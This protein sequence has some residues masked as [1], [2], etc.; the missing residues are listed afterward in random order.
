MSIL[1]MK[2]LS[3]SVMNAEREAVL[4]SLQNLGCVHLTNLS[5][6]A[7]EK[8]E[9]SLSALPFSAVEVD[10][11]TLD[12]YLDTLEDVIDFLDDYEI[13]NDAGGLFSSFKPVLNASHLS[14]IR[15]Q[16]ELEHFLRDAEYVDLRFKEFDA[17][18]SAL[19]KEESDL[20]L[21]ADSGLDLDMLNSKSDVVGAY[22]GVINTGEFE[23]LKTFLADQAPLSEAFFGFDAEDGSHVYVVYSLSEKSTVSDALRTFGFSSVFVSH[24]SG[25]ISEVFAELKAEIEKTSASVQIYRAMAIKMAGYLDT[26][27]AVYDAFLVEKNR[28][29]AEE[30]GA[31]TQ[32]VSFYEGWVPAKEEKRILE[33]LS[34]FEAVDF[35]FSDPTKEEYEEVP[36]I[37]AEAKINRPYLGLTKMYSLPAYGK[38]LDPTAHFAPF[39]FIF[40]GFCLSDFFYGLILFVLMGI[41]ARKAKDNP[42]T[43]NFMKMLSMAGFSAMIFGVLFGSFFGDLFTVYLP[44][45]F[46]SDIGV[47]DAMGDPLFVLFVALVIGAVHLYYGVFLNLVTQVRDSVIDGIGDNLPWLIF[48]FGFFGFLVWNWIGGMAGVAAPPEIFTTIFK[49]SLISGAG[50]ILINA[51]RNGFKKGFGGGIAGFFGGLYELYGATGYLS[52]LLSYA[53]LLALG[54]ST[55][56]I[57]GVFNMLSFDMVMAGLPKAIGVPLGVLLLAFGHVFNVVISAFGAFVHSLRLQFVEFFSKFMVAGGKEF[58]PLSNEAEYHI[59]ETK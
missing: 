21:W 50:L 23:N 1:K 16:F 55:G 42:G 2:K 24:R 27:R 34:G 51:A 58:E 22:A 41:L 31:E 54:L 43:A 32:S 37:L 6:N 59:V 26:M 49:W 20:Q 5:G 18:L 44:V 9:G 38:S 39:Y 4:E 35:E 25:S 28:R 46:L 17:K 13:K 8:P 36:V 14:K 11:K 45:P 56:V 10:T 12:D 53:R 19:K 47:L 33:S 52:D 15:S 30:K 7:E 40:Y 57:A 3:L 48:L 29:I